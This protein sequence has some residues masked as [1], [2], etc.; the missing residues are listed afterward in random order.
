MRSLQDGHVRPRVEEP[1]L[2]PTQPFLNGEVGGL[3]W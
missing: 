1:A 3:G 2:F